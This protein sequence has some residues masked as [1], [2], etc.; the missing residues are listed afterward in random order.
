MFERFI[1]MAE[2]HRAL[3]SGQFEQALR[4][5]SDPLVR[6]HR[7]AEQVRER[8]L[9][10]LLGRARRRQN[11][12]GLSAALADVSHVMSVQPEFD[13]AATL[14]DELQSEIV[15][16]RTTGRAAADL[17]AEA[18]RL[19]AEGEL[20]AAEQQLLAAHELHESAVEEAAVQ[21]LIDGRRNTAAEQ[22]RAARVAW[23][24]GDAVEAQELL[25]RARAAHR[26]LDGA[27]ELAAK[28]ARGVAKQVLAEVKTLVEGGDT[29]AA[30]ALLDRHRRSLPE[31]DGVDELQRFLD[32]AAGARTA[33]LQRLLQQGELEAA[34]EIYC[35]LDPRLVQQP[36]MAATVAGMTA[37]IR[38]IELRDRGDFT[39]AI[40]AWTRAAEQLGCGEIRK[41]AR[42][43]T[44]E[45][46]RADKAVV[47]ARA[48]AAKG[49]LTSARGELLSV[50]ER[51]PMHD[52]VR[53]EME[54]LDRGAHDKEQRLAR[55][56]ELARLGK[57]REAS[58]LTVSLAVAGPA[59]QEARLLLADVQARID[60]VARG[61][62]QVRRAVHGRD[63]GSTEGLQH[64]VERLDQLAQVQVDSEELAA[65]R[66]ALVAEIDGIHTLDSV[67]AAVEAGD[68][69][70]AADQA[71]SLAQFQ[72]KLL[73]SDRLDARTLE[74][75]DRVATVAE[76]FVDQGRLGIAQ[77]WL[78]ALAALAACQGALKD[79]WKALAR[80]TE[81][82]ENR[83]LA[84]AEAGEQALSKRDL[85]AAD[86]YLAQAR[87]AWIDGD[88]VRRLERKLGKVRGQQADLTEVEVLTAR[89]DFAGAH[90]KL[91]RMPPTPAALRTRIF[92]IKQSLAQAQGLDGGFLLR[93]DEG[94]EFLVLR[95]D[96]ISVGNVRDGKADL[97]VLASIA[98]RHA[99]IQRSIS[100]HGGMQDRLIAE[101]GELFVAGRPVDE[102]RLASGDTVRLGSVLELTYRVPSKRSMTALLTLSSGFQV[103]GT[104][105]VLLMKDRGR[106]GR[107]LIGSVADAHVRVPCQQP[108]IE[109]FSARDGQVRVRF[110]GEGEIDGRPFRGE[111]PVIAGAVVRCGEVSFVLQPL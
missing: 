31:L 32:R 25:L 110:E 14:R 52:A 96:S 20:V 44:E 21:A 11:D 46:E 104:D 38:G 99:R 105:K 23:R 40:D 63:S 94:G 29:A 87:S 3:R 34:A 91:E 109:L 86:S 100:F 80:L 47:A 90:R 58:A 66:A 93:V 8:A 49:E 85:A 30:H 16:H 9:A 26:G 24:N 35:D 18:R 83:A 95:S 13:G 33:E 51:W 69:A 72:S 12:G 107:V 67:A 50:L 53:R 28:I 81:D 2:A 27:G 6:S 41:C 36:S 92:D 106:D 89:R 74:L 108:E 88:P 101:R 56:R 111:H 98:G 103:S 76:S 84:A 54:I 15:D 19:V 68:A 43:L 48:A 57:L 39:G 75:G 102:H 70:G 97:A 37:L 82:G 7:R 55:A 1:R 73:R 17:W 45:R 71:A 42:R 62:D 4:L 59:G 10:G 77:Q 5:S 78:H 79:R 61:L 22:L 60:L 65:L 64:C